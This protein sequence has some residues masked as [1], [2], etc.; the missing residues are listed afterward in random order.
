MSATCWQGSGGLSIRVYCNFEDTT[1]E[2]CDDQ[3][4]SGWYQGAYTT[5]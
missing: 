4:G 3:G 2:W 5:Q 1:I